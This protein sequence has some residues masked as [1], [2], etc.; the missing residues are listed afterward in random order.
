M[1]ITSIRPVE[2]EPQPELGRH[3]TESVPSQEQIYKSIYTDADGVFRAELVLGEEQGE[4][5][6]HL[7][8]EQKYDARDAITIAMARQAVKLGIIQFNEQDEYRAKV[9]TL[10]TRAPV[11]FEPDSD[12]MARGM[13]DDADERVTIIEVDASSESERAILLSGVAALARYL[14]KKD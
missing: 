1:S 9:P 7:D 14:T 10:M 5:Y 6:N 4:R 13:W 3:T 8:D 2:P 11:W 12:G